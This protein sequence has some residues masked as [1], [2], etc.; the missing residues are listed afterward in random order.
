VNVGDVGALLLVLLLA[1]GRR[2][3]SS[4]SGS[5]LLRALLVDLA[6]F[7]ASQGRRLEILSVRRTRAY[8]VARGRTIKHSEHWEGRAADIRV[9]GLPAATVHAAIDRLWSAGRLP[10]LGGLALY[11]NH[12]HVDVRPHRP[13]VL[14]RWQ[15]P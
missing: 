6:R 4:L 8:D 10:S 13:G 7:A 5:S 11:P 15:E 1:G 2:I 9:P 3:S 12:V 14:T